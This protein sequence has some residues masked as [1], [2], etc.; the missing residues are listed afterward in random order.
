M[1]A[2]GVA[3]ASSAFGA[4]PA[5]MPETM[6]LN[7]ANAMKLFFIVLILCCVKI[8]SDTIFK[9]KSFRETH[10]SSNRLMFEGMKFFLKAR[11]LLVVLCLIV[12][13]ICFGEESDPVTVSYEPVWVGLGNMPISPVR[14]E[15]N[16][17][18]KPEVVL[19]KWGKGQTEVSTFFDLPTGATKQ[20]IIYLESGEYFGSTE[21]RLRRGFLDVPIS[22]ELGSNVSFDAARIGVI[23]DVSGLGSTF[24]RDRVASKPNQV[25]RQFAVGVA[26]PGMAPDRSV[27]YTSLETLF[28][29]EGA[30][31]L[32]D[33]E[34]AAIKLAV[35]QGL[36]LVFVGG[37]ISPVVND[38]RWADFLPVVPTGEVRT[39]LPPKQYLTFGKAISAMPMLVAEP[40]ADARLVN[41]GDIAVE[42]VRSVGLGSVTFLAFDPFHATWKQ[43]PGRFAWLEKLSFGQ[44][45]TPDLLDF[46]S[47]QNG[48]LGQN[49][50]SVDVFGIQMPSAGRISAVLIGYLILV[51]PVNFLV[52][53]KLKRGELAWI[54]GPLIA[55]GCAGILFAFA[56]K[57]YSAEASRYSDG[58]L[59]ACD[60]IDEAVFVGRQQIFF[61]GTGRY[62]LGLKGVE[63]AGSGNEYVDRGPF[64]QV[65]VQN[66]LVDMGEVIA[67]QYQVSNL[68]FRQLSMVQRIPLQAG[69]VQAVR[70]ADG[71]SVKGTIKNP[72]PGAMESVV[73]M[74]EGGKSQPL[75]LIGV[76]STQNFDL[77]G[78]SAKTKIWIQAGIGGE[79]IGSQYGKSVGAGSVRLHYSILEG[80]R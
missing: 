42:A 63:S 50:P 64:G 78:I 52:L 68:S 55:L 8:V 9:K 46:A 69:W 66:E 80:A 45:A 31:R 23:S 65:Q 26:K 54:T 35:L 61:P 48:E 41:S 60:G 36:N 77:K 20:R 18:G 7:R 15:V 16:N 28:L 37:S 14:L 22:I 72:F 56:G 4:H 43:W 47:R 25:I 71:Q 32:T 2:S 30:E 59:V 27:G 79:M 73:V 29:S 13:G 62:D 12:T 33:G 6:R 51:V 67:P 75:G 5:K 53:R 44:T 3:A 17:V 34:I 49:E 39:V 70:S 1:V 24:I 57:L 38:S 11:N 10:P 58:Y 21:I 74:A 76:G 19:V 40:K